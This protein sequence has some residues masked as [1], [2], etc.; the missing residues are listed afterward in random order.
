MNRSSRLLAIAIA[1]VTAWP[2]A[3]ARACSVAGPGPHVVDPALRATDQTPPTFPAPVSYEVSRGTQSSGG[4]SHNTCDGVGFIY[5]SADATDDATPSERIGYRLSREDGT[6]PTGLILPHG[7]IEPAQSGPGLALF[8]DSGA[9]DGDEP[10]DVTLRVVAI[11]LAGNESAP[12]I[13]RVHDDPGGGCG[14]ARGGGSRTGRAA[15]VMAALLLA[16]RRRRRRTP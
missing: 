11:D 10:I 1:A 15:L 7:A 5:L 12:Q 4:C 6:L 8:W 9:G 2:P 16:A 14:I 3:P 13:V